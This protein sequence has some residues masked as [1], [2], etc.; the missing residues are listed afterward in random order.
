MKRNVATLHDS[1][2]ADSELVAAIAAEVIA[3]LGF[4]THLHGVRR[5]AMRTDRF[6]IRPARQEDMALGLGFV[7]KDGVGDVHSASLS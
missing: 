7:V 6:T 1:A 4:A 5:A 2:S 3:L